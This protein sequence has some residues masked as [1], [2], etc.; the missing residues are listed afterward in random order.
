[1][2]SSICGNKQIFR[3]ILLAITSLLF[4]DMPMRVCIRRLMNILTVNSCD[5]WNR[6]RRNKM[7]TRSL[8]LAISMDC[9]FSRPGFTAT[10]GLVTAMCLAIGKILAHCVKSKT[11]DDI[12]CSKEMETVGTRIVLKSLICPASTIESISLKTSSS[13][14]LTNN[15]EISDTPT[16]DLVPPV[17]TTSDFVT[18]WYSEQIPSE[19]IKIRSSGSRKSYEVGDSRLE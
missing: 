11:D 2:N 10:F 4:L 19:E 13:S 14:P 7:K 6:R 1:M 3:R 18:H 17:W 5:Y 15:V 16:F 8:S 12:S 9:R